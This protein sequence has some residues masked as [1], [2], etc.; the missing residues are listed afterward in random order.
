MA[1]SVRGNFDPGSIVRRRESFK[2]G[3]FIKSMSDFR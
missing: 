2:R 3:K 1:T